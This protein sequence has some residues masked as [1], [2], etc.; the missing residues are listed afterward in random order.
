MS[1]SNKKIQS[2]LRGKFVCARLNTEGHKCSGGSFAHDPKSPA[3]FVGRGLGEKNLQLLMLTPKGELLHVVSGYI[4]TE[5]LERE[6]KRGLAIWKQVQEKKTA[7]AKKA[8][9]RAAHE[10]ALKELEKRPPSR[11]ERL[12]QQNRKDD[13]TRRVPKLTIGAGRDA[14]D[15]RFARDNALLPAAKFRPEELVGTGGSFFGSSSGSR[16]REEI[17]S[18]RPDPQRLR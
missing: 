8:A 18:A 9:V 16:P 1:F 5:E 6:L 10:A 11:L 14:V 12:L 7:K 17:G 3:G 13:E 4:G 2:L 15:H